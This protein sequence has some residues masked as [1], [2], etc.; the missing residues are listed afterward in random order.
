MRQNYKLVSFVCAAALASSVFAIACGGDDD[1][2]GAS[3]PDDVSSVDSNKKISDL[4]SSEA[5]E[6]CEDGQDFAKEQYSSIDAKKISCGIQALF[7]SGASAETD[8]EAQAACRELLEQ[9]L[10]QPDETGGDAGTAEDN[11]C[12]DF[13]ADAKNCTA[14]VGEYNKCFSDQVNQLKS[15][16][17]RDFCAEAKASAGGETPDLGFETPASCTAISGKCESVAANSGDEG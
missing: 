14:T 3:S 6:Y 11:T 2:K 8:G 4:S 7:S 9:C 15:L 12:D 16:S 5:K 1:K 10:S 13:I 17:S